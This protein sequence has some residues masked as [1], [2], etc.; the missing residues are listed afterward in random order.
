VEEGKQEK[1]KKKRKGGYRGGDMVGT[2]KESKKEMNPVQ[3]SNW[4]NTFH[5]NID[6]FDEEGNLPGNSW[7]GAET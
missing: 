7:G 6:S 2:R 4:K 3:R 5:I 1:E